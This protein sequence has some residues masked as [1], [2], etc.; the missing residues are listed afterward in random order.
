MELRH[1]RYFIAVAEESTLIAAAKRL[2]L[3]QPS[4]TRQIR[5]LELEVGVEL[6]ERS[7]RGGDSASRR[8][9]GKRDAPA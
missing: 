7:A 2:R 4:L 8:E 9:A 1:L 6:F 3:A 5:D